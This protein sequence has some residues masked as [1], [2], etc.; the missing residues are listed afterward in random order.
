MRQEFQKR[1]FRS[2][3]EEAN[4]WDSHQDAL[5]VEFK[6]AAA[7]GTLGHGTAARKGATPTTTIRLVPGDIAL[8]RSQA[9]RR[10]LRYQTYLKMMIHQ[11]LQQEE[12]HTAT[13]PARKGIA[14]K[15]SAASH[16]KRA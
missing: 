11:A 5:A 15:R 10:G 1:K 16:R 4:W 3:E 14:G 9:E 7:D 6:R 13:K 12:E 8:A 2:E